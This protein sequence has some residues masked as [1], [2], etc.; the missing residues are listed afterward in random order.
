MQLEIV[1]KD[2]INWI[3]NFV[4]VNNE[5]LDNWPPCPFARKTYIDQ[6]FDIRLGKDIIIDCHDCA[7]S[8]SDTYDVIIYAYDR[9]AYSTEQVAVAISDLNKKFNKSNLLLLDDHPDDIEIVNDV[10][11]NQGTYILIL[12]Q[13]LDKVQTASAELQ[14]LGYYKLWPKHYYDKVAGWREQYG[15]DDN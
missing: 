10:S 9:S 2:I 12:I 4:I 3:T 13:R 1:K 8:W 5:K 7:V 11:F 6:K 15:F 14:K